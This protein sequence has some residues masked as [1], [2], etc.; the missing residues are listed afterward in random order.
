MLMLVASMTDVPSP[1]CSTRK[2]S[3]LHRTMITFF[4]PHPCTDES[5]HTSV[6][7]TPDDSVIVSCD[8]FSA[9]FERFLPNEGRLPL[10]LVND[11]DVVF[12]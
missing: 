1:D 3:T 7:S 6:V 10:V 12:Y 4:P 2:P 8:E 5:K 11:S 9:R